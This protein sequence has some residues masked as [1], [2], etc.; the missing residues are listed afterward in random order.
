MSKNVASFA[1]PAY[2]FRE[3]VMTAVQEQQAMHTQV[4]LTPYVF[5]C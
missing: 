4:H 2:M 5:T 3:I 1:D